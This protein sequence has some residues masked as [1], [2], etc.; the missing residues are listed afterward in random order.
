M[1]SFFTGMPCK[2]VDYDR[3]NERHSRMGLIRVYLHYKENHLWEIT[4]TDDDFANVVTVN[5]IVEILRARG[6]SDY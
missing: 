1:P 3:E 2:G 4:I 5:D 6:L